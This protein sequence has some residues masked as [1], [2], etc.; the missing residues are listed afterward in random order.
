MS[1]II[2]IDRSKLFDP[3]EFLGKGWS[4]EEQDERSLAI[5]EI[6]VDDIVLHTMMKYTETSI[7]GEEKLKRL[8]DDK[9]HLQLDAGIFLHFLNNKK[10][11]TKYSEGKLIF[12]DGTIL[13]RSGEDSCF[14]K[15]R[16]VLYLSPRNNEW[17]WY[18]YHLEYELHPHHHSIRIPV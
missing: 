4:I 5:T 7:T 17:F 11:I 9:T 12:F 16:F 14:D 18:Y 1:N 15:N 10:L 13:C 3:V 6:N 8:R 2:Q